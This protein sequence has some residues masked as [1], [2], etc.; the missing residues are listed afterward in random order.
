MYMDYLYA[1]MFKWTWLLHLIWYLELSLFPFIIVIIILK[2]R[3]GK[4][5][6]FIYF[7]FVVFFFGW[8]KRERRGGGGVGNEE[9]NH[10][11]S[12]ILGQVKAKW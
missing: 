11:G 7:C 12:K 6:Y 3:E 4:G 5:G 8:K 10:Y 9:A 1:L 2:R